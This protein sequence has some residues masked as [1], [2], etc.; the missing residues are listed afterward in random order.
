MVVAVRG[1]QVEQV[2]FHTADTAVDSHVV[3]IQ[4]NKQVVRGGRRIV[5]S[6]KSQS[7]AHRTVSDDG[8]HMTL[9]VSLLGG[10]DSHAEGCGDRIGSVSAGKCIVFALFGRR[11]GAN[12]SQ[13]PV[14]GECFTPSCEDFVAVRLMSHVPYNT[15]IRCIVDVVQGYGQFH[16]S[17]AGSEVPRIAGEFFN[18]VLP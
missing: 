13:F 2:L 9:V 16:C 5:Q 17:E 10:G 11:E 1:C 8:Y 7:S 3:I 6:F 4:D 14:G 12:T 18:N 15:V